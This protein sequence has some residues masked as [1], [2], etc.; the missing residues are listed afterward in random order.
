M[1]PRKQTQIAERE[2][3][4][5]DIATDIICREGPEA[6]T[7]ERVLARVDFSKGTLYN[8]FTCR[9]DL[10]VAVHAQCF[11]LHFDYF[12]RGALF[13]GRARERFSA[14]GMGHQ[15]LHLLDPRPFRFSLND[16]ILE[17]AS[18]RWRDMFVHYNRESVGVFTGIAR[19]AIAAGDLPAGT[20]PEVVTIGTWSTACGSEDLYES[21]LIMRHLAPPDF[22]RVR[23][24]LIAALLDGFGWRPLS[25]EHDYDATRQ[26]ALGEI[27]QDE[28]RKLGL[29][30][31]KP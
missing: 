16:A 27:F 19:D 7:M 15:I 3:A 22:D 29:L 11:A 24:Q 9:E 20:D 2:A 31:K 4:I 18:E 12:A 8:H 10:L 26:R 21:G 25:T 13:R 23:N 30:P 17:A 1:T 28:A 14:A 6:L 5:L